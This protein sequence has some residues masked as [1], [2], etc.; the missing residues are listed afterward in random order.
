MIDTP[1]KAVWRVGLTGGIGSGKSTVGRMLV[2]RGAALIDADQIAR[3]LTA[4]GGLAMAAI[5]RE[6]GSDFVDPHGALDRSRMRERAFSHTESR[7]QLEAII[8]PLVGQQTAAQARMAEEAGKHLL[9][10]DIPLLVESVQWPRRLDAVI[11]VDCPTETQI[12]RVM[13]RNA[14]D[15]TAIEAIISSQATRQRRRAA[16]DIVLFNDK[17]SID[18][19]KSQVDALAR[20][21]GL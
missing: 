1:P 11:V 13:Q 2:E 14:L 19:L 10:F 21:F 5:A 20:R 16:A 4:P 8:H 15:R 3:E 6:F 12:A 17:L 9:V 7:K 18:A